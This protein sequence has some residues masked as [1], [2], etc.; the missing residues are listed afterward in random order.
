[1][2]ENLGRVSFIGTIISKT[3][4]TE[5]FIVDDADARVLVLMNDQPAFER[6]KEGQYVRVFGKVMGTGDEVEIL[7]DF[8]QDFSKI[9]RE[10]YKRVF[11]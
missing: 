5:S 10:L 3:A 9:D 8:V 7:A 4:E 2:K 6:L 1:M 11:A